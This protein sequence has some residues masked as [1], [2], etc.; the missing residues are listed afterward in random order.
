M[1][2]IQAHPEN[3]LTEKG[4]VR[5]AVV[6]KKSIGGNWEFKYSG[7]SLARLLPGEAETLLLPAQV[8]KW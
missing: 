8:A 6:R 2:K 3:T 7:F 4:A 5:R 1:K